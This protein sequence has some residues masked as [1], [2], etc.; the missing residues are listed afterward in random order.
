[1]NWLQ[2]K[3]LGGKTI[4]I[5]AEDIQNYVDHDALHKL[6]VEEFTIHCAINI[7]ANCISK[8]VFRTYQNYKEF[9]GAE[10][11]K[12]NYQ[13]NV[14][15]NANQFMQELVT[16]LLYEN[17]CLVIETGGQLIIAESYGKEEFALQE[18]IFNSVSRKGFTFNRTFKMSEV[19]Y[20]KLNNRNIRR[21]LAN[22]CNGYNNL[23][24]DSIDKYKKAGGEKGTLK[25]DSVAM[26]AN[27]NYGGRTFEE[28]FHDLMNERFKKFFNSRSAVLPLFQGFDYTKQAAEQ[29]KKSTSEVKDVLDF[30]GEII[31]TVARAFNMP[32]QI[33]KGDVANIKEATKNL[34]T[35]GIDPICDMI[36][37]ETNRKRYGQK[38]IE[39]GNYIRIDTTAI[40]HTD[41]F[42]IAEKIDKLIASGMYCVDELRQKVGDAPLK[43]EA[44]Q[45]YYVTKNYEGVTSMEGGDG[46]ETDPNEK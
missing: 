43:T 39:K 10:S 3:L 6:A 26:G 40:M 15:Q 4:E 7:I 12:W 13:P 38:Q 34:L 24:N 42:D 18:T 46:D 1:M 41:I 29:S 33:I 44:S 8:C 30:T 9:E 35:F 22:L 36:S 17:E 32:A 28:V 27:A 21:L 11:Y 16:K 45:K 23:L 5:S 25:I 37:V 31:E 14:N 2:G 20:Y 19:L